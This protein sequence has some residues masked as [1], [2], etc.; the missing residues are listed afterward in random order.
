[1]NILIHPKV[2]TCFMDDIFDLGH[3]SCVV[4]HNDQQPP[5]YDQ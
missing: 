3:L 4:H 5:S 1:M 2:T